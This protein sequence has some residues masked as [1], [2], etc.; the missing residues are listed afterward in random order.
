MLTLEES[1]AA[2]WPESKGTAGLIQAKS[3]MLK[4]KN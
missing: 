2:F 4:E 1:I 3:L